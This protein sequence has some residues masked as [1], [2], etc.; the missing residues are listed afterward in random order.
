MS[1][2]HVIDT[3]VRETRCHLLALFFDLEYERKKAFNVGRRDI[4]LVGALN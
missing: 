3:L 1:N 2:M 4:V